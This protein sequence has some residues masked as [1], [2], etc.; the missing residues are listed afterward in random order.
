M[1]PCK[2]FVN[3]QNHIFSLILLLLAMVT[4]EGVE[5]REARPE[6][7]PSNGTGTQAQGEKSESGGQ[8]RERFRAMVLLALMV[9]Q[10]LPL[11]PLKNTI[12]PSGPM[13]D[14]E[15]DIT[16]AAQVGCKD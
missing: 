8:T 11:T 15:A 3:Q 4:S 9:L 1:T 13:Q 5:G 16:G 6:A 10:V 12:L 14:F 7:S 2:T